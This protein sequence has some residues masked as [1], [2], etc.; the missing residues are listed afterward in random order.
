MKRIEL[1]EL[2]RIELDI[3]NFIVDV[4]E[5]HNIVYFLCGGTMLGALR[6]KG[7]IPWDDDIDIMLPRDEYNKFLSV[8]PQHDYYKLYTFDSVKNYPM[9]YATV[10]DIRTWKNQWKLRKKCNRLGVNIDVFPIDNLPDSKEE[11]T[12]YY[13]GIA[14]IA[15]S[16]YCATYKYSWGDSMAKSFKRN[17]GIFVFR[18]MESFHFVNIEEI[19]CRFERYSRKYESLK[20]ANLGIT[21]ISHYGSKEANKR[22]DYFPVLQAEFE[23]RTYNIPANYDNYLTQL[24]GDYMKMPP[25]EKQKTHHSSDCYWLK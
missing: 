20:C 23:G 1:E 14:Q 7:F 9:A 25:F 11:I 4:C 22:V 8:F 16:T 15:N 19:V 2:K 5:S 18:V 3:L 24:Y 6:H 13:Q 21:C 17:V 10:N 12:A